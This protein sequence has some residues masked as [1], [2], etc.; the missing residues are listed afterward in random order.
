MQTR[1]LSSLFIILAIL[2]IMA[3]AAHIYVDEFMGVSAVF[4]NLL[5]VTI[6]TGIMTTAIIEKI[7]L[8]ILG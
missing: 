3:I 1:S 2:F 6:V 8:R 7:D 5:L 4:V